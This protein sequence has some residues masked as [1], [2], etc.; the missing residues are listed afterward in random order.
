MQLI[1]FERI[2]FDDTH[3]GI[4]LRAIIISYII[5]AHAQERERGCREFQITRD[6]VRFARTCSYN[7]HSWQA[8]DPY[9]SR[10]CSDRDNP[11]Q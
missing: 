3:D 11:A 5:D 7:S 8:C 10:I 9:A 4:S 2:I 6:K 1:I